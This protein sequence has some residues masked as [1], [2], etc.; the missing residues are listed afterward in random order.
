[1]YGRGAA[2]DKAGVVCHLAA[3]SSY[4]KLGRLPLNVKLIVEGEEEIGS[5]HLEAFLHE[6]KKLLQADVMVLTDTSNFDVGYPAL[7]VALRGLVAVDVEVRSLTRS[8]HSGMWGGAL[9]DPVLALS[10]ILAKL[11]DDEGRPAIP[12][13]AKD[14][15]P[16]SAQQKEMLKKLP[17]DEKTFRAQSGLLDKTK[18][19]GGPEDVYSKMW[20]LPSISVNAIEASSRKNAANIINDVAWAKVGIRIVPDMNPQETLKLLSNFIREQAPWGVDVKITP[21]ATGGWWSTDPVGPAFDAARV[22]LKKG[23]GREPVMMGCGGSIP[24][25]QPFSEALG[26]VPALLIGVEDPFTNAHSENESL[27]IDDW[28]SACKSAIYLYDELAINL[29]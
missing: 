22:A 15:K 7:T 2:D 14:V 29:K 10:K 23:Y 28:K 8:V 21:D 16:L 5:E 11:V 26:G 17:Y 24:F 1:L 20:H 19:V 25:V 18:I 27:H 4:I 3:I 12:G 9:P 6:N 13:L